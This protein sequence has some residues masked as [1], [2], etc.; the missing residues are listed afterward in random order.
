MSN[1]DNIREKIKGILNNLNFGLYEREEAVRL[2]L[3]AAIAGESI[4]FLGPPGTAKSM[5]ARKIKTI[6]DKEDT[7]YFEYLLN[8]FSTPDEI[9]G[10]VSLK[11][12]ENDEYKRLT[13]G[14]L[15]EANAA[16]LD[17]IWKAGPAILNTLLIII[18]EKKFHNGNN[19]Q[20]VPLNSLIAASNELPE[21]NRGLEALW[22]RFI[23]RVPVLP[24]NSEENFFKVTIPEHNVELG[25]KKNIVITR[26]ELKDWSE[27]IRSMSIPSQ[28]QEVISAIRKELTQ[29]NDEENREE[30]EKYYVSDRR[31]KKIIHLLQTSA[32]LNGREK[33]DLMDCQL[34]M[35]SLWETE[36][37][38][39]EIS[40]IV[41]ELAQNYGLEVT[42]T[43]DDVTEEIDNFEKVVIDTWYNE[44]EH[45]AK[46]KIVQGCYHVKDG[47]GTQYY[48]NLENRKLH[49]VNWQHIQNFD[50]GEI[51]NDSKTISIVVDR[52]SN[53]R[54]TYTVVFLSEA[55]KTFEQNTDLFENELAYLAT[56]EKFDKEGY[57]IIEKAIQEALGSLE[58]YKTKKE[59]PFTENFFSEQEFALNLLAK[60]NDAKKELEDSKVR[61]DKVR[62]LYGNEKY[63]NR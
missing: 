44:I 8:E 12:L 23:L 49:N 7:R 17:E 41:K 46:P 40:E 38:L 1:T 4:F 45:P 21:K 35:Y 14:Y 28:I 20:E 15:P 25:E 19:V 61:L 57:E 56:K 59:K 60:V 2:S 42:T 3:L 31:W 5:I 22:D 6:F 39:E 62:S 32:F 63:E 9:F 33:V 34:M 13:K 55:K 24:V 11:S 48:I 53:Q 10:P 29:K 47:K 30:S 26:E 50:K 54:N 18:N 58:D 51:S 36:E 37:Q 52:F 43:I 27:K 16:F